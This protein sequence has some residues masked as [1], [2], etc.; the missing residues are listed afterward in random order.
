LIALPGI[1][2]DY[3]MPAVPVPGSRSSFGL[4]AAARIYA[5]PQSLFKIHPQM[6]ALLADILERDPEGVLVFFQAPTRAVTQQFAARIQR[7]LAARG[8][9]ARGQ[10][11][12]LPRMAGMAFRRALALA[13]VV[14]DTVHWSG[15]NTSLDAFCAATPVVTL[16]GRFMRGRQTAAMLGMMGL[17]DL[18]AASPADYVRIAVDAA[19]D[20]ERNAGLRE[21][22]VRNRGALF[23]RSEP[24]AALSE[25]LLEAA[26]K[27]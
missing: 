22:V 6:D 23:D 11:K 25:A 18:V 4:P 10:V 21:A 15:G 24:I 8:M 27:S 5:C 17:S 1:G 9:H 20:R 19:R 2:V 14:L 7:T 12:F 16:P 26:A 13:D 3:P